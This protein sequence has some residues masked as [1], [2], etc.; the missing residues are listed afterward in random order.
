M[1]TTENTIIQNAL[2]RIEAKALNAE[3]TSVQASMMSDN[4][5]ASLK[6]FGYFFT[7]SGRQSEVA[8]HTNLSVID[9]SFYTG[10][11]DQLYSDLAWIK[12]KGN[13]A[14][15]TTPNIF[16]PRV[17]GTQY[18]NLRS[19]ARTILFNFVKR[20][21]D[22]KFF[23]P[24]NPESGTVIGFYVLDEPEI[25]GNMKDVNGVPSPKLVEIVNIFRSNTYCRQAPL[26]I[27]VSPGYRDVIQGAKLFDWIAYDNYYFPDDQ[28][29]DSYYHLKSLLQLRPDQR[30]ILVPAATIVRPP[31][32]GG[33]PDFHSADKML[34]AAQ[35]D[36]TLMAIV[37]YQ[38]NSE[39]DGITG[40][41]GLSSGLPE[42]QGLLQRYIQIG[43]QVRFAT[44][45][46]EC[47]GYLIPTSMAVGSYHNIRIDMRNTGSMTWE[48][49]TVYLGTQSPSD[50]VI[51]GA[52]R[53]WIPRP[54]KPGEIAEITFTV[55]A[56]L[57]PGYYVMQGRMIAE[58]ITW[59]GDWTPYH[60]VYVG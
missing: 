2:C 57:S 9:W 35:N 28:F 39:G 54:I 42:L 18:Y 38:W 5:P 44:A 25:A 11:Y 8:G 53:V 51:W 27:C 31:L 22:D 23:E 36:P 24:G 4:I 56:P 43:N 48:P 16:T 13:K 46:A 12:S 37:P 6:Y 34:Q 26:A 41:F 30:T 45:N 7:E 17:N 50:N 40:I 47:L 19:D 58:G 10:G 32:G 52:N 60:I 20:L 29:I 59:F 15:I 55:R 21:I 14:V 33:A 3:A 1:M 49:G